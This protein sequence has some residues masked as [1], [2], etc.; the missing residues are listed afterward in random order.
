[1]Q[2]ALPLEL[3]EPEGLR[4]PVEFAEPRSGTP[5][6]D[7]VPS[8]LGELLLIGDGE[9]LTGL[10]MDPHERFAQQVATEW[11]RD[12]GALREAAEQLAAYFA[13]ELR[14]FSVALAPRGTAFQ[15]TVWQAL[16]TIPY[17]RTA[18]YGE[19]AADIGR[20]GA[21]RAVG[22]AN[23]RNPISIVVPCHRV[24]GANGALVGYGGGISRKESLLGLERG[25]AIRR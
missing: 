22:M 24:I 9:A 6:Y 8:P 3:A 17:G 15:R 14:E 5:L 13:G 12:P 11:R 19:I 4:A 23:N 25:A 7:L 21:S 2:D 10:Y 1:M 18:T 20:P 16:T